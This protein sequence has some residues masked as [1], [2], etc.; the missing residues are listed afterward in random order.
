MRKVL[1]ICGIAASLLYVATD[2]AASLRYPGY[3]F[4]DQAVSELFAMGAPTS[5]V[6]VAF[7]TVSSCLFAAFAV[8][9][10]LSSVG[11]RALC[12]MAFMILGNAI[13]TMLLWNLFPMHMRGIEP[14]LTDTMHGLLAINPFVLLTIASGI[15]AFRG[16]FRWY[17]VGTMLLLL[18]T[19]SLAFLYVPEVIANRPTP[20]LGIAERLPQYSHQL[21]HTVLAIVLLRRGARA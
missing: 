7:F 13:D 18:I 8:G 19:A 15:A 16:W 14:T 20:G 6:V 5:R 9:V 21:W 1:V 17:S 4:T 11:N 10:W 12:I 3:S 2:I